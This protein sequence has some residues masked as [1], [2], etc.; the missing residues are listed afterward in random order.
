MSTRGHHA[1]LLAGSG[2]PAVFTPAINLPFEGADGSTTITDTTGRTWARNGNA[3]I[4]TAQ[5]A[6]GTSS[7]LLDGDS[8]YLSTASQASIQTTGNFRMRCYIRPSTIGSHKCIASKRPSS[9]VSEFSWF[10]ETTG[11]LRF[12]AWRMSGSLLVV[13][14]LSPGSLSAATWYK[15]EVR[16]SGA[17]WQ[18]LIDDSVVDSEVQIDIPTTNSELFLIGRDRVNTARDWDGY[19]DDFVMERPA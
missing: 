1:L 10:I 3:Q 6:V 14:L 4:S 11:Q 2:S 18:M 9:G 7:L 15:V 17:N 12:Y 8:D 13:D 5:H 19:I 16:K